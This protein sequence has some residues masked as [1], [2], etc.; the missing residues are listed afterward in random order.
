PSGRGPAPAASVVVVS[1]VGASPA[2]AGPA[3]AR[4]IAHALPRR[5]ASPGPASLRT[6]RLP[7]F[8]DPGRR[9]SGWERE[10]PGAP[11]TAGDRVMRGGGKIRARREVTALARRL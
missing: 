3:G 2:R 8:F 10:V 5:P 6:L 7:P 11:G 1:C 4:R 9:G